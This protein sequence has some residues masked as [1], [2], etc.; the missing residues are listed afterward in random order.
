[1]PNREQRS[2]RA[3]RWLRFR[4]REFLLLVGLIAVLLAI[5]VQ[6]QRQRLAVDEIRRLGG[7]VTHSAGDDVTNRLD[8]V[9][10]SWLRTLVGEPSICVTEVDLSGKL[11]SDAD[12]AVLHTL[13]DIRVLRLDGTRI[14]DAA[15]PQLVGL[16]QLEELNLRGTHITNEG[17]AAL[18]AL[19]NV[20]SLNLEDT[21]VTSEAVVFLRR[22]PKLQRVHMLGLDLSGEDI[23]DPDAVNR[24]LRTKN[25]S[26]V[27]SD[28]ELLNQIIQAW[29]ERQDAVHSLAITCTGTNTLHGTTFPIALTLVADGQGRCRIS[30]KGK[31]AVGKSTL[32]DQESIGVSDGKRE[33]TFYAKSAGA[34]HPVA[35]I[36]WGSIDWC[37]DLRFLP[38]A[39]AYRPLRK[40][41]DETKPIQPLPTLGDGVMAMESLAISRDV[42]T[43]DGEECVGL[44]HTEGMVWVCPSRGYLPLRYAK[45]RRGVTV[46][47]VQLSYTRRTEH[48]W[49]LSSSRMSFS[50]PDGVDTR[51]CE[52]TV[53]EC[54][55]N[56]PLADSAFEID[57]PPRTFISD[58]VKKEEYFLDG[59]GTRIPVGPG[60]YV[61]KARELFG[62]TLGD[63]TGAADQPQD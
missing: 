1:M 59:D 34:D 43:I 9:G 19:T 11:V 52:L 21:R 29:T 30:Y 15:L 32:V 57:Y 6:P 13:K 63:P 50:Q 44:Y 41:V 24:K 7:S 38:L 5:L 55:V 2:Q 27:V 20:N 18:G 58:S 51:R 56:E 4:L 46:I 8:P 3:W 36:S 25:R 12:L 22:M 33:T 26:D 61:S 14:T 10:P 16:T 54:R 49:V 39:I 60:E 62:T 23:A 42:L 47:D 17:V 48:E 45:F 28:A 35:F 37:H 53:G 31:E 40:P